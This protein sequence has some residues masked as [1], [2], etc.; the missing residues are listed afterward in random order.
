MAIVDHKTLTSAILEG[1]GGPG[2]LGVEYGRVFDRETVNAARFVTHLRYFFVRVSTGRQSDERS[3]KLRDAIREVYPD[4]HVTAVK[5]QTVLELRLGVPQTDDEV[6]Y[7][8][9]HVAHIVDEVRAAGPGLRGV[10]ADE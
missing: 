2:N 8:T 7:L 6:T 3:G 1:V 5:L 9:L 10:T 4:A